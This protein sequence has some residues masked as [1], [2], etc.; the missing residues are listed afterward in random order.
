[1]AVGD[2][3]GKGV[4]AALYGAFA[5]GTVRARAF[6]RHVPADLLARVNRTLRRRGVEGLYCSLT[7]ALFDFKANRLRL[8]GSGLPYPLH[9]QAASGQ[10]A[11]IEAS[12]LPL[13]TF[14]DVQYDEYVIELAP[15]D[16][17]VFATD[18]LTEARHAHEDYGVA[19]LRQ[20]VQDAAG[21]SA[22]ALGERILE[23]LEGFMGGAAPSDD[24]TLVVV[25]IL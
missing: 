21:L 17:F 18:G 4:P 3:T 7:Y 8:A 9:R 25:K 20:L 16:V 1:V 19:R 23:D 11:E 10:C 14:D 15:G 6:E 24:V 13:G 2:V 22:T 12:G 5:S